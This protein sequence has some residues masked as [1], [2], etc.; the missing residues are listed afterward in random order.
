MN[1]VIIDRINE[2]R[3]LMQ[4]AGV[5]VY[6]ICT[7][8][9][10]MSEYTGAYFNER[11]F[12]SGFD[13]SAG[14]LVVS[15]KE[16]VLFTDGRYFVQAKHQ[17]EGTEIKLM[18][19]GCEGVP[20]LEEYCIDILPEGGII[21]MDGKMVEAVLGLELERKASCKKGSINYQFNPTKV[22]WKDRPAFPSSKAFDAEYGQSSSDKIRCLRQN[23]KGADGHI[24]ASLDDVCWLF[25]IRGR[26]IPCNPVIMAYGYISKEEAIIY[27]DIDRFPENVLSRFGK[28]GIHVK[29]Y[30]QIYSDIENFG[31]RKILIDLKRVNLYIYKELEKA[32]A[33]I[34]EGQNPEVHMKAVKNPVEIEN[35]KDIHVEDGAA[36]TK[37][38]YWI[39]K[40]VKNGEKVTEAQAARYLDSLRGQIQDFL[41][42]SFGTISAYGANAA[43]MHYHAGDDSS[44]IENRGML[45]VDSGGQYLRGTTDVTRTIAMGE[46]TQEEIDNYTLTLKGMLKLSGAHFLYGCTGYNLDILARAPLWEKGIDYRCGTGHGIGYLLNVHEAPNGFRWRHVPGKND[47]CVLEPGMVTSNEPGVYVE[48][49]Y[50]IRIENEIIVEKDYD[51]EYGTWLKFAT[52]TL[53][54]VELDAVNVSLLQDEER[55]ALNSYHSMVRDKLSP[56]FTGEELVWLN[57]ATRNI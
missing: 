21:G 22:I 46:L 1:H 27:T 37:F 38:I 13:G 2:T 35:L 54:P 48:G 42:P 52:L 39:K 40:M 11:E 57:E 6:I 47:L 10:H 19:M 23:M 29:P 9:Y 31:G 25:N 53:V 16:A 17:L 56:Y 30:E 34:I 8:D 20:E 28:E 12:L 55:N 4:K 14:T 18:Q 49:K 50:G 7:N 15:M 51:N 45:L 43:M 41:E 26:D 3:K 36:V 24:V 32:G 33:C 44:L 5:D